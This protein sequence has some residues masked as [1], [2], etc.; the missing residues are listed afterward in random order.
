M[1]TAIVRLM[2]PKQW[3]KNLIIFTPL[4]FSGSLVEE[5][6]LAR[7]VAAF[8]VFCL[9]SGAVYIIND[10]HDLERDRLHETKRQRPLAAGEIGLRQATAAA[11]VLVTISLVSAAALSLPFALV[12]VA[13]LGLQ[14]AYTF[15]LKGEA[16]LDVMAIAGGFVLRVYAGVI[17]IGVAVSPWIIACT[18]LLAMFLGFVKRRHELLVD[19]DTGDTRPALR[20]YTAPFLD[21]VITAITA[22]TIV[23]YTAYT[24][25]SPAGRSQ[26][27]LVATVPFVIYGLMRYLFIMHARD[28]GGSPDDVLVTDKP[29]LVDMLLWVTVVVIVL[30]R[31][32]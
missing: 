3:T 9:L 13:Y 8:A 29:L 12:A 28:A 10:A 22:A 6:V 5:M 19:G 1:L 18:A 25:V 27:L 32:F 7:V 14:L 30:Y 11:L 21:M 15:F 2:R 23:A 16:I 31:P 26:P 4:I 20:H 17:I 24:L